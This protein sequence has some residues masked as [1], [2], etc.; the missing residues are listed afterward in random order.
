MGSGECGNMS[1]RL[2]P[3]VLGS[4]A[5]AV[6]SSVSGIIMLVAGVLLFLNIS[7]SI[8][9]LFLSNTIRVILGVV[10][11][12]LVVLLGYLGSRTYTKTVGRG[13][14]SAVSVLILGV[15]NFVAGADFY[16]IGS[17]LAILGAVL[18]YVRVHVFD[19]M[20]HGQ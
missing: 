12:I 4:F 13:K 18:I 3:Y 8:Y 11:G 9:F 1:A 19:L 10:I 2:P 6:I 15:V 7:F 16:F 17:V 5:L 14:I 20:I